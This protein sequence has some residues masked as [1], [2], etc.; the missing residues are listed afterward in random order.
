M[1]YGQIDVGT[2]PRV[3]R[4]RGRAL[5]AALT[6]SRQT[7]GG[8]V[9]EVG[10]DDRR[11]AQDDV[12]GSEQHDAEAIRPHVSIEDAEEVRHAHL[13][14][15]TWRRRH[16]QVAVVDLVASPVVGERRVVLIGQGSRTAATH[17]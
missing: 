1:T 11:R 5:D 16:R 17:A 4:E 6:Q 8:Q 13:M 15:G 14:P 3:D 2:R 7:I 12:E 9:E 10:L